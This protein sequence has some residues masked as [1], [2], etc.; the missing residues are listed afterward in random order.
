MDT[1]YY[2]ST[3]YRRPNRENLAQIPVHSSQTPK[4]R[5]GP[6]RII[7]QHTELNYLTNQLRGLAS[8]Q[9]KQ[10]FRIGRSI[11]TQAIF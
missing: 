9:V 3:V 10:G 1:R 8:H 2:R 5:S 11:A 4:Q 7:I 6:K